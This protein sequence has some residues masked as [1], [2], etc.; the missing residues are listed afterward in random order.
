MLGEIRIGI[1]THIASIL[2]ID[3]IKKFNKKYPNVK[4]NVQSQSTKRM[5]EML[6]NHEIDIIIDNYPITKERM[7]LNVRKILALDTI[8][9]AS[10]KMYEKYNKKINRENIDKAPLILPHAQ[11]STRKKLDE[12][13]ANRQIKLNP[14]MEIA[15][16]EIILKIIKENI[17]IRMDIKRFDKRR[18]G[19]I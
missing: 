6:E 4:L 11:A 10:K 13:L 8:F 15:S 19:I 5:V 3:K 9:V 16:T 14:V 1:P 2:L 7:E 18:R 12:F 17:G